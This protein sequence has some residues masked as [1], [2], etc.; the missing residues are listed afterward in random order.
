VNVSRITSSTT[1]IVQS[2]RPITNVVI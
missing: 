2:T 1:G